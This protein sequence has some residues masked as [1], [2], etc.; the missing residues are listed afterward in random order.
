MSEKGKTDKKFAI[1]FQTSEGKIVKLRA[2][3]LLPPTSIPF[4]LKE[5]RE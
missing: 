3:G 5:I 2:Y 1:T 4:V